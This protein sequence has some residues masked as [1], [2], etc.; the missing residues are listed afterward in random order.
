LDVKCNH[1]PKV[2]VS[3]EGIIIEEPQSQRNVWGGC[4]IIVW[5]WQIERQKN[6]KN[7]YTVAFGRP[8]IDNSSHNNQPKTSIHDG[9][10]Y[11]EDVRWLGGA[12]GST[13][14]LFLRR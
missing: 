6:K 10:E 2:G 5:G 8:P 12:G 11:V 13:I 9:G 7:K 3:G 1:Q 14:P 4:R